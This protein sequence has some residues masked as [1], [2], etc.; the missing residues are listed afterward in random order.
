LPYFV[1][2]CFVVLLVFSLYFVSVLVVGGGG[3]RA[4][5][6]PAGPTTLENRSRQRKHRA[7]CAGLAFASAARMASLKAPWPAENSL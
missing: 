1:L 4:L 2:G 3:R 7:Q 6:G 5:R